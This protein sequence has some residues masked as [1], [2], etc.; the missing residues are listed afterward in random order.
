MRAILSSS[1]SVKDPESESF[2]AVVFVVFCKGKIGGLKF[3]S[4]NFVASVLLRMKIMAG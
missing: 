2:F 4:P 1:S 3:S